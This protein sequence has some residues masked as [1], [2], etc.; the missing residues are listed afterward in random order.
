[1]LTRV[2]RAWETWVPK[3]TALL[4]QTHLGCVFPDPTLPPGYLTQLL[5]PLLPLV[6]NLLFS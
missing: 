2:P 3:S 6:L 4:T 1:M 5:L